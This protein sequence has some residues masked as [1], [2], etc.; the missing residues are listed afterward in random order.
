[1][2]S[3]TSTMEKHVTT[4]AFKR[5]SGTD[6]LLAHITTYN[7]LGDVKQFFLPRQ[8]STGTVN[9]F[10]MRVDS[11]R[12]MTYY[13]INE[14]HYLADGASKESK[15]HGTTRDVKAWR[16]GEPCFFKDCEF[17]VVNP[18]KSLG[19]GE[20]NWIVLDAPSPATLNTAPYLHDKVICRE[21][22]TLVLV[23]FDVFSEAIHA[24]E[25]ALLD[26]SELDKRS[27]VARSLLKVHEQLR[28]HGAKVATPQESGQI[29]AAEEGTVAEHHD[30][31]KRHADDTH[32]D[33][34]DA[35]GKE[36]KV[37]VKELAQL[38]HKIDQLHTA[39]V[40]VNTTLQDL[41]NA[42]RAHADITAR[43][44]AWPASPAYQQAP[45]PPYAPVF[46][47]TPPPPP[48]PAPA[49]ADLSAH[50]RT[51][52]RRG[53]AASL[54]AEQEQPDLEPQIPPEIA[55][56]VAAVLSMQ[57]TPNA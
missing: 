34:C 20:K 2:E 25:P 11:T 44:P 27:D 51:P 57:R 50:A 35:R 36:H 29:G 55:R 40:R 31:R 19:S 33:E 28:P 53:T 4:P 38:P 12:D 56:A 32:T 26:R 37:S 41:V 42:L 45:F 46:Y 39:L 14:N 9:K 54:A 1:M 8:L 23:P 49:A 30:T 17:Y 6:D 5:L 7:T 43:A 48:N 10:Y 52:H 21:P 18:V 15:E 13:T 16:G 22:Y 47:S 24:G 3:A